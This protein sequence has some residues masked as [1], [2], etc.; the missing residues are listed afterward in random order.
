[1]DE[2]IYKTYLESDDPSMWEQLYMQYVSRGQLSIDDW[3]M[4]WMWARMELPESKDY[5]IFS[6][7]KVIDANLIG[8]KVELSTLHQ[9]K[10]RYVRLAL[11]QH[12]SL[13]PDFEYYHQPDELNKRFESVGNPFIDTPN[14]RW[15]EEYLFYGLTSEILFKYGGLDAF[16][17]LLRRHH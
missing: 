6:P 14:Y 11:S 3:I 4:D 5:S 12:G 7:H 15:W 2:N 1:M 17:E 8:V 16:V 13:H 9:K 10:V